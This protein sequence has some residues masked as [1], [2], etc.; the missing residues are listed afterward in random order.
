MILQMTPSEASPMQ[1]TISL[2]IASL[3]G[4]AVGFERQWSGHASGPLAHFAGVRTFFLLGLL[5]GTAGLL[6]SWDYALVAAILIAGAAA[7][8]G[9]AYQAAVRRDKDDVDGTTE[10]AA[11]VV[12]GLGI[13]AGLGQHAIAGGAVAVVVLALRSKKEL[14]AVVQR[15][16]EAEMRATVQFMVLALVVL[17]LLPTGPYEWLGGLR[18]RGLWAIVLVIAGLNFAGH[19]A[20]KTI[21]AKKGYTILG[22]IGGVISSTAVTYQFARASKEDDH[23]APLAGGVLA[24]CTVLTVRVAAVTAALNVAVAREL[25]PYLLPPF[26]AGLGIVLVSLRVPSKD[27]PKAIESKNPLRLGEALRLAALFQAAIMAVDFV[28]RT[29]GTGGVVATS[30]ALGATDVDALTVSMTRLGAS[31]DRVTLAAQGIGV[32]ILSN[33]VFKAGLAL[34]LGRGAFRRWAV[35]GLLVLAIASAF[36]IWMAS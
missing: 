2:A 23:G 24:A 28:S 11:L 27:H 36:G 16:G 32:G 8:I 22:L 18:P 31:P 17:P 13:L 6:L 35:G 29:W 5:A 4:L 9:L 12:L 25:W 21:G 7:F 19:V 30:V 15:I 3:V 14:H 1:A 20:R 10:G 33:T 34:V 26:V